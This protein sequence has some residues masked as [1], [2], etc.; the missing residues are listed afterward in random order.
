MAKIK[1][2]D[3]I[4]AKWSRVTPARTQD[5]TAGVQSPR[6]DW[7]QATTAANDRF[8]QGVTEAAQSGRFANGVRKAGTAKWQQKTLEKGPNRFAEGVRLGKQ[9]FQDGFAPF[10]QVIA[11]VQLPPRG[12]KGD[13][14]NIERV[15]AIAQA[16]HQ[17][18]IQGA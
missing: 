11:G 14:S 17:R 16:L 4:A 10:A 12:P 6:A 8:V 2:I 3:Q 9:D 5:Y 15:R 18:K 7:E 13:P 1:P